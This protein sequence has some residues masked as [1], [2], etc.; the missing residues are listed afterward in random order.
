V[1]GGIGIAP[2]SALGDELGG[3]FDL[4]AG[5]RS[6]SFGLESLRE[7]A[8]TLVVATEDG[9]EGRRGRIP[10]FVEFRGRPSVFACGPLPMLRAVAE[11]CGALGL[12]C[13][14]SMEA[15]MACG[16][17]ACLGCA[18]STGKG[19]RR[20]CAD[21]PIFPA[22][23]IFPV[24]PSASDGPIFPAEEIFPVQ[25]PASDGPIF[26]AEEIFP[27][28]GIFPVEEMSPRQPPVEGIG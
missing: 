27:A 2:L 15:L 25:P 12:P 4:Y 3:G 20:C 17:G 8:D 18:I 22:E 1:G 24:Q 7:K 11:R 5:F 23:E 19:N 21:G 6:G 26:P 28:E 9:T 14:I 16:V 10:D 13:Y